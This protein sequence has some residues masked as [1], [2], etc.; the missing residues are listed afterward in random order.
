MHRAPED[1]RRTE[2]THHVVP[3]A[4][5]D[6]LVAGH[7]ID[8][9]RHAH[10]LRIAQTRGVPELGRRMVRNRRIAA[11]IVLALGALVASFGLGYLTCSGDFFGFAVYEII[12]APFLL[13]AWYAFRMIR[14]Y[15]RAS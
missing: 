9:G 10:S 15:S 11:W 13:F 1:S 6:G 12:A 4:L 8:R 3:W 5:I 14:E 2:D 7:L